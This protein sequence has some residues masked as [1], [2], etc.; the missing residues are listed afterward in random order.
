MSIRS[1]KSGKFAMVLLCLLCI[2]FVGCSTHQSRKVY[3]SGFLGDYLE[4]REG[5]G[6]EAQLVY[7]NPK[8][9]FSS[10]NKILL[11]PIK[12]YAST[13]S[14]LEE[15]A[16]KE[17]MKAL[18]DYFDASIRTSLGEEYEFVTEPGPDVMEFRIA[19]TEVGAPVVPLDVVS[20][21]IP[22]GIAISTL[23]GVSFGRELS[24]GDAGAEMEILDSQTGERMGAFVDRRIGYKYTFKFDKFNRW[25]AAK[26]AFDFWAMRMKIRLTE[27]RY[28]EDK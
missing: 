4:F 13:D 1:W 25:R 17:Y 11:K 7:L 14:G 5:K 16:E 21:I 10:K 12:I 18:L 19:V 27:L 15:D 26:A 22:V 8:A 24:V 9:D 6:D 2:I 20:S 23:S 3:T 28:S